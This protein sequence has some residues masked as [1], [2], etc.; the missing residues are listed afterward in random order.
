MVKEGKKAKKSN[1]KAAEETEEEGTV[2]LPTKAAKKRKSAKADAQPPAEPVVEEE[3]ADEDDDANDED[4]VDEDEQGD[5]EDAEEAEQ[6]EEEEEEEGEDE[7]KSGKRVMSERLR[8]RKARLVGY[9]SLARAAGYNDWSSVDS[10]ASLLSTADAVRLMR[11][12][13]STPGAI[14]YDSAEF[15]RRFELFSKG[16]PQSAARETQI[17]CDAVLR[18]VMNKVVLSAVENQ[19]KTITASMMRSVLRDA[20]QNM[21]F[22]S[23]VPPC[24]LLRHAQKQ[25][26][27]PTTQFDVDAKNDDK[28]AAAANKKLYSAWE[29]N[30]QERLEERRNI[31]A[32]KEAAT[33]V[34][35]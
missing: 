8:K 32:A 9:R 35:A 27:V 5:A 3:M 20:S 10:T 16:V 30:E 33:V 18:A 14:S 28:K 13:P 23:T 26:I 34:A 15:A 22:T 7:A 31:K 17:R 2:E 29:K 19:K 11:F 12:V 21:L 24:G 1:K 6:E 25:G 4:Y